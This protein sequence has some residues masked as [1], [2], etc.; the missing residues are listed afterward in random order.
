MIVRRQAARAVL[1][2]PQDRLLLL[3]S[4]DPTNPERRRWWTTVGGGIEPEETPEDAVRREVAEEVGI[5]DFEL[6]PLVWRRRSRFR[7]MGRDFEQDNDYYLARTGITD[8]D[9]S[10]SEEVERLTTTHHHWW[11]LADLLNTSETVYPNG[12]GLLLQ[13][14]LRDGPPSPPI[15]LETDIEGGLD[16]V[17]LA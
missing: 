6:G 1:L 9:M 13:A 12:L 4:I 14:L 7:F 16:G 10:S 2:D 15:V 5:H 17:S 8:V 11:V 3:C